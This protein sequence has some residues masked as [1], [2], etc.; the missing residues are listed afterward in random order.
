MSDVQSE[1][2][3]TVEQLIPDFA[4]LRLKLCSSMREEAFWMIYFILLVPRL[5]EHDSDLLST[6]EVGDFSLHVSFFCLLFVCMISP[7]RSSSDILIRG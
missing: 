2:A 6:P 1:H 4:A 3:L 5:S 7:A